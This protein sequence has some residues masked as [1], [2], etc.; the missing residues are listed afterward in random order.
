MLDFTAFG[1]ASEVEPK[2]TSHSDPSS[3]R[4]AARRGP[5]FFAYS[6]MYLIDTYHAVMVDVEATRSIR[7]IEVGFVRTMLGRVKD[8]FVLDPERIIADTAYR[9][10]QT[11]AGLTGRSRHCAH[12][13]VIDKVG[14]YDGTWSRVDVE[15]KPESNQYICPA[16]YDTQLSP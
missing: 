15:G 16:V 2:F 5:A 9:S 10:G 8:K 12:A 7:Q 4:T 1:A 11:L 6:M 13:P 14:R 3:Q